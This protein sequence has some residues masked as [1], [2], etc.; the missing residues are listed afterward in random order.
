MYQKH[1]GLFNKNVLRYTKGTQFAS[2]RLN[3]K[4]LI[5]KH[6]LNNWCE[7]IRHGLIGNNRCP[8]DVR[9]SFC[10]LHVYHL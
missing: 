1:K 7:K 6:G 4:K 9:I 5:K 10:L 3:L 2:K 8:Y